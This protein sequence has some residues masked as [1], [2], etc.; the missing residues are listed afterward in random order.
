MKKY[1]VQNY[2]RYKNDVNQAV[3]RLPN[4]P[5]YEYSRDQLITKF[6]PLVENLARK[7]S[8]TQQA[9]GVMTI[10]DMI[11]CGSLGLTQAAKK[12]DYEKLKESEDV[13]QT[14][15]SFFS[16]RIK[17]SIRR[18]IDINRG[19][20]RIPEHKLNEIRK[21]FGKDKKMVEMFFNSIFLSIDANPTNEDMIYQIPDTSE[22]YNTDLLNIYLKSLCRS[23][24][25]EKEYQVLRLSYGLD[26]EKHSATEIANYL[27]IEGS[28]SYVRV[29]QLKKQAV[30]KLIENVDHSQVID[31]L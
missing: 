1:N 27:G 13:E 25:S 9:S 19:N 2:I 4:I 18:Q 29:S 26:C 3:K 11:Q 8:T 22:P 28:S 6:L 5:L 23:H 16:K 15:K 21:N 14:L 7:F 30:E 10:L 12:I 17:G 31:F 20:I 24:L